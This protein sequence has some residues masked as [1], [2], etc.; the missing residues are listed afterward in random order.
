MAKTPYKAAVIMTAPEPTKV[1][2]SRHKII[3]RRAILHKGIHAALVKI[4]YNI[5]VILLNVLQFNNS[6]NNNKN[7][8]KLYYHIKVKLNLQHKYINTKEVTF[9]QNN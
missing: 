4:C 7:N 2:T 3:G 8:N 5:I 6:N 9:T 1:E